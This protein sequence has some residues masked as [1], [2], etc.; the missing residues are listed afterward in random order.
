MFE[1][2]VGV[3]IHVTNRSCME[4][5]ILY[6]KYTVNFLKNQARL[7]HSVCD[8]PCSVFISNA[9]FSDHFFPYF[10]YR[11]FPLALETR[12]LISTK[13]ET[14]CFEQRQASPIV[15]MAGYHSDVGELFVVRSRGMA[16]C[17]LVL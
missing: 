9:L 5:N 4:A 3:K 13:L 6:P 15:M 10:H 12:T 16:E 2:Q 17:A 11:A 8:H 1:L 14:A 7:C